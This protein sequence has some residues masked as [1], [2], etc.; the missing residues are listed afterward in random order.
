MPIR[1]CP[2]SDITLTVCR[3]SHL[4]STCSDGGLPG[5]GLRGEELQLVVVHAE[6]GQG[7]EAGEG[8]GRQVVEGVVGKAQP[9]DVLKALEGHVGDVDQLVVGQGQQVEEAQLGEGPRLDLLHPVVV[10]EQLLQGSQSVKRLL[11]NRGTGRRTWY[12]VVYDTV[13]RVILNHP[14]SP[15]PKTK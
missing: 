3:G 15:I 13:P 14:P 6:A 8:F 7:E 12:R 11:S 2:W 4:G 10:D 1:D 9:L 5:H